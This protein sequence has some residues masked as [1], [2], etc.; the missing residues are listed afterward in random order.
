[1]PSSS[2]ID[3][4]AEEYEYGDDEGG[5]QLE[6][7]LGK[8]LAEMGRRRYND[9]SGEFSKRTAAYSQWRKNGR[10]RSSFEVD[11]NGDK[12]EYRDWRKGKRVGFKQWKKLVAG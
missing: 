5:E 7:L 11:N 2:D 10:K 1:M 8:I 4:D 12:R 3:V 9:D 6:P